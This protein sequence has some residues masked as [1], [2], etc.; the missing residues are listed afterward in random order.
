MILNPLFHQ[1]LYFP[2]LIQYDLDFLAGVHGSQVGGWHPDLVA[3]SPDLDNG[4]YG[5]YLI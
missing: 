3:D 5:V 2:E 1:N 4:R